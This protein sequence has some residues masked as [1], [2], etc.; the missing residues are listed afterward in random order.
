MSIKF[1][2]LKLKT[3][4]IASSGCWGYGWE[5]EVH[6]PGLKWGAVVSKTISVKKREG[7]EP[8]RIF[9]LNDSMI[10]RV[11]LQNC[12]LSSFIDKELPEIK[13]LPYPTII[14]IFGNTME[15]WKELISTLS[16][17]GAKAFE[18]N[19]SCPNI[20]G[21]K[22]VEN[23]DKCCELISEL[24]SITTCPIIPKI[25]A[26]NSPVLLSQ[27]LEKAGADAIVCSNTFPSVYIHNGEIF[28]GGLSGPAI[29]PVVL[30]TIK[31]IKEKVNLDIA[32]CGGIKSFKDVQDYKL[33]GAKVFVL[34]SI[35]MLDPAIVNKIIEEGEQQSGTD[36][37]CSRL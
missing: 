6:F 30:K 19:F 16:S 26:V 13:R 23:A 17:K 12:G 9:E 22:M 27:E 8:P 11:G 24:K 25:N 20:K 33:V 31:Q 10:N 5:G 34:G 35:L 18:L 1:A 2:G 36:N 29:K 3:P 37:L 4:Y 21:E 28:E 15:E 14:S 7:N 32:G